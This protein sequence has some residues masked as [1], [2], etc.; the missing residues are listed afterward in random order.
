MSFFQDHEVLPSLRPDYPALQLSFSDALPG[1]SFALARARIRW[2]DVCESEGWGRDPEPATAQGKALNEAVERHAHAQL[3]KM[4]LWGRAIDL[5]AYL[6]PPDLLG[7]VPHQYQHADFP[8]APF[9]EHQSYWWLQAKAAIDQRS[10]WIAADLLC[11]PRAFEP[12]YRERLLTHATTSGCASAVHL[13]TASFNATLEL[14]ERDAFMR[15]WFAQKGGQTIVPSSLPDRFL[16]RMD[17]L[18]QAGCSAG[19]QCLDL[20]H[21]PVWMVWAQ[22]APRH[23]TSIGLATGLDAEVAL[24]TALSELET[25]ALARLEGVPAQVIEP[26]QVCSPAGH[27]ALYA[28]PQYFR[29]ADALGL[30]DCAPQ[31]GLRFERLV[32]A[33]RIAMP[34][35]YR[36]LA[37][38]GHPVHLVDLSVAQATSLTTNAVHTVRAVAVGLIPL[39]FGNTAMPRAFDCW[40]HPGSLALHPFS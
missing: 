12:G 6:S 3:P 5:P 18:W 11:S 25:Q 24:E 2:N 17:V 16:R 31:G 32:P 19:V 9:S 8:Y 33:F 28:T 37:R 35:L 20:G 27:S 38:R 14:V 36:R 23:F 39:A 4:A 7:Y 22:H 40:Q 13:D 21:H 34:A 15:H 30:G 26:E 29:R 10:T 1:A